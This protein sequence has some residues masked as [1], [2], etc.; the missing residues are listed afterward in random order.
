M[1]KSTTAY[2]AIGSNIE[3]RD[4]IRRCL[5]LLGSLPDTHLVAESAWYATKP[6]GIE[7]QPDFINLVVALSTTLPVQDLLRHTQA[8]EQRLDRVRAIKNGPRTIDLDI[9]LFGDAIIDN[10][11]LRIPHSALLERDFMLTPLLD[12]A[13]DVQHPVEQQPLHELTDRIRY[14]QIIERLQ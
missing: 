2:I 8:I 13:A 4:N 11:D 10:P 1:P 7:A 14:R 3:P 9:L 6:W 12:I 5:D